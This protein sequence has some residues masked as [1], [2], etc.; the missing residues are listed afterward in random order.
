M[1]YRVVVTRED[2]SWLADVPGVPGTHTWAKDLP[3]L[4]ASVREVIALVEDLP[5]GAEAE[6]NLCYE[7]HACDAH[8]DEKA[9]FR[10]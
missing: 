9:I 1:A 2:E 3:A 5:Q 7:Y 8:L 6:L 10:G 4:D